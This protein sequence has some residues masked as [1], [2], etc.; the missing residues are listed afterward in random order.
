MYIHIYIYIYIY[1]PYIKMQKIF[2]KSQLTP[3]SKC[4]LKFN[5]QFPNM[6]I[7]AVHSKFL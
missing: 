3:I 2:I 5:S 7:Y 6:K 1:I 4:Y